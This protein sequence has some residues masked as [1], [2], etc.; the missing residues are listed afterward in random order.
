[1]PSAMR[2]L[3]FGFLCGLIADWHFEPWYIIVVAVAAGMILA[4]FYGLALSELGDWWERRQ[5]K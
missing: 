3:L 4:F 2:Y 5:D 1:M